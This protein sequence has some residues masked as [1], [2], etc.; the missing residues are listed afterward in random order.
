MAEGGVN[1]LSPGAR[2]RLGAGFT[3]GKVF[4]AMLS[5]HWV[6]TKLSQ[7]LGVSPPDSINHLDL[8]LDAH[9]DIHQVVDIFEELSLDV[10]RK[11]KCGT[12]SEDMDLTEE[13][14][15]VFV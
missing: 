2:T 14:A 15:M 8:P 11:D 3:V 10:A 6:V 5:R 9:A 13:Q 7:P 12:L 4:S 1:S